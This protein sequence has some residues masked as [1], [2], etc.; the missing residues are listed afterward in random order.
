M[1]DLTIAQKLLDENKDLIR[2]RIKEEQKP[3]LGRTGEKTKLKLG[4]N[5]T[6]TKTILEIRKEE[7]PQILFDFDRFP[8]FFSMTAIPRLTTASPSIAL[9]PALNFMTTSHNP[10]KMHFSAD[11]I[12]ECNSPEER[13]RICARFHDCFDKYGFV[14]IPVISSQINQTT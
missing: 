11:T 12:H 6:F 9:N 7:A 14:S 1:L 3:D 13:S 2:R 5:E 8:T 4:K 10:A